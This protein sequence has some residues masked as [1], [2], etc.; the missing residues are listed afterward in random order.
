MRQAPLV[1]IL[2]YTSNP[3]NQSDRS[4]LLR[5]CGGT[6]IVPESGVEIRGGQIVMKCPLE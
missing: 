3:Y 1:L 4:S 6:H 2:H 5:L